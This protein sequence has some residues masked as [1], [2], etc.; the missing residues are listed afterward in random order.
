[1][2]ECWW[3]KEVAEKVLWRAPEG[4]GF[5]P[6]LEF[7]HLRAPKGRPIPAQVNEAVKKSSIS[8]LAHTFRCAFSGVIASLADLTGLRR[9]N[10]SHLQRPGSENPSRLPSSPERANSTLWT[11]AVGRRRAVITP[12]QGWRTENRANFL[13]QAVEG[14]KKS[15]ATGRC[16]CAQRV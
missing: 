12:L 13:T 1:M 2:L 8:G 3:L 5:S 7:P 11:L 10:F 14:V 6:A 4:R 16:G 15:L 9:P